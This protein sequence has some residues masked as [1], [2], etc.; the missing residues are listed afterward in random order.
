MGPQLLIDESF[1]DKIVQPKMPPKEYFL[2]I[3]YEELDKYSGDLIIDDARG[4]ATRDESMDDKATWKALPAVKSGQV[5]DWK[6]AA[7]YSYLSSAPLL[8]AFAT[9][10]TS[11]EAPPDLTAR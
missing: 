3:S 5:F 8:D 10:L 11:S 2:E 1:D 9:A 6:P 7:P 4:K